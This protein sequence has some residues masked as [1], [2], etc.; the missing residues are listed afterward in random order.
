[1]ANDMVFD[2]NGN[3]A[4][5]NTPEATRRWI[6]TRIQ[7]HWPI[8]GYTVRIGSSMSIVPYTRYISRRKS[9]VGAPKVKNVETV[10]VWRK[11][12]PAE[13]VRLT[14]DNFRQIAGYLGGD[15]YEPVGKTPYIKYG[16]QSETTLGDWVVQFSGELC[17]SF[18]HE[19]YAQKFL[20]TTE[21]LSTDEQYA[22]ITEL[23]RRAMIAQDAATYHGDGEGD[24]TLLLETTVKKILNEL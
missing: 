17:L 16:T 13:A 23:V 11:S 4:Y 6:N 19:E 3:P 7:Q 2:Q 15:Y 10:K 21:R 20:T 18:T 14:E 1:M 8:K 12:Y 9:E 5:N 22:R 24:M